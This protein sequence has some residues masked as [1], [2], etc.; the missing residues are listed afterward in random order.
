MTHMSH[1]PRFWPPVVD[2]ITYRACARAVLQTS[3]CARGYNSSHMLYVLFKI[4]RYHDQTEGACASC[5]S[6][7]HTEHA[8]SN[9][10]VRILTPAWTAHCVMI[11]V[12][13]YVYGYDRA[14]RSVQV[15][16]KSSASTRAPLQVNTW[17]IYAHP[18]CVYANA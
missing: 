12:I 18:A 8:D 3:M 15:G 16:L 1:S 6:Q 4:C 11:R 2:R 9:T 7:Q 5:T 17:C 14:C 10:Y 13:A